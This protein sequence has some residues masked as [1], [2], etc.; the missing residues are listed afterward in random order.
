[1]ISEYKTLKK[2]T[3]DQADSK[4][5]MLADSQWKESSQYILRRC[6]ATSCKVEGEM[7]SIFL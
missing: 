4:T 7:G 5:W 1:M 6:S 2:L 3:Q